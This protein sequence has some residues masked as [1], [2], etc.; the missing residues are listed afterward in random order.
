MKNLIFVVF[1]FFLVACKKDNGQLSIQT[2]PCQIHN[3]SI[4]LTGEILSTGESNILR[5]GFNLRVQE[6]NDHD[7]ID[8]LIP[9]S[10]I[11]HNGK[12]QIQILNNIESGLFYYFRSYA[13]NAHETIYGNQVFIE[14]EG[15]LKP[16]IKSFSPKNGINGDVVKIDG[17]Y[18][19]IN[20][21]SPEVFIGEGQAEIISISG[22]R[23]LIKVPDYEL[24]KKCL[25]SIIQNQDTIFSEDYY[26]LD[27]PYISDFSPSTG[28]DE[29][30]LSINGNGF[31][32]IP[33]HNKLLIGTKYADI[34]DAS[35]NH[36]LVKINSRELFPG[37]YHLVLKSN[38]KSCLSDD[39]LTITSPWE[40]SAPLPVSGFCHATAFEINNHIYVCSGSTN[41]NSSSGY[42]DYFFRFD[43]STSTWTKLKDFPGDKRICAAAF[44]IGSNAYF[45]MGAG[46]DAFE[47]Y[48]DIWEYNSITN[49][50]RQLDN[51]PGGKTTNAHAFTYQNYGYVLLGNDSNY[52]YRF[53]SQ[54]LLW[55]KLPSFPGF[56]RRGSNIAIINNELY[57]IGG[58]NSFTPDKSDI[59]RYNFITQEW[60]YIRDYKSPSIQRP[61][62]TRNNKVYLIGSNHDYVNDF[63]YH[64]LFEYNPETDEITNE[65][66]IFPGIYRTSSF[67][68]MSDQKL[69]FGT[70]GYGGLGACTNDFWSFDFSK[71]FPETLNQ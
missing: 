38:E 39:A 56:S 57:V 16:Q 30:T 68:I 15:I 52:F 20:N 24:S 2:L 19:G 66:P 65:L 22:T 3:D 17:L 37:D 61:I 51:Y 54:T 47:Y 14:G 48:D 36:L 23:L 1:V 67:C 34:L 69:Y 7:F 50:W 46:T 63:Y 12:Y 43:K 9:C 55:E 8:S 53:D 32:P 4:I 40:E 59:W 13:Q 31:S 70:G 10:T 11:F 5:F 71:Y 33:W 18:F 41:M 26:K 35:E 45:G 6:T 44:V 64:T 25:I 60:T 49:Q 21:S 42:N 28:T 58:R 29:I 62:F 27:G